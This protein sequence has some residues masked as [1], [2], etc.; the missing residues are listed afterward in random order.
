[1]I[2]INLIAPWP[3]ALP[4]FCLSLALFR[5]Q[6][7]PVA[8]FMSEHDHPASVDVQSASVILHVWL[9]AIAVT[10]IIMVSSLNT[11]FDAV[12]ALLFTLFIFRLTLI[13]SLAGWLPREWTWGLLAAGL[14]VAAV[15]GSLLTKGVTVA[16]FLLVGFFISALG[17]YF[18]GREV[19]G[20]G[21]IWLTAGLSAWFGVSMTLSVLLIALIGFILFYASPEERTV[22]G[23]LGPWL[24]YGALLAMAVTVGDPL[25]IG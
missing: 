19:L 17:G 14:L 12:I 16:G 11:P 24:G 23:P 7:F 10:V 13:D 8:S 21:D 5:R 6:I 18:A 2:T 3:L 20:V 22:G 9:H 25:L 4:L 1:M 15:K